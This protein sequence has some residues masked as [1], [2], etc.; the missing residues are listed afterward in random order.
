[1]NLTNKEE[2]KTVEKFVDLS[3]LLLLLA[4]CKTYIIKQMKKHNPCITPAAHVF[5]ISLVFSNS[6]R[7]LSQCNTLLRLLYLLNKK[8]LW[9]RF[10]RLSKF[11]SASPD[12]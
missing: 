6:R 4:A 8:L 10:R 7:L 9:S 2:A 5:D 3:A 12:I 1:M 11:L